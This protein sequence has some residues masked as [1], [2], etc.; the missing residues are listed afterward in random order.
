[1]TTTYREQIAARDANDISAAIHRRLSA[2]DAHPEAEYHSRHVQVT[3]CLNGGKASNFCSCWHCTLSVCAR[4]G[5]YEG[6][7]TTHCPGERVD[8]DTTQAV[9]T[10]GLDYTTQR[11]WHMS[12]VG[13]KSRSPLFQKM[14]GADQIEQERAAERTRKERP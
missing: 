4:C 6:G 3:E 11:G 14:D 1:M 13:M 2:P 8:F 12:N 9:Y 10:T 7:L 5:A